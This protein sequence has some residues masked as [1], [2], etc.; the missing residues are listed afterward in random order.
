VFVPE[1]ASMMPL[2]IMALVLTVRPQG[3]AGAGK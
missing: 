3:L 1:L 2:A